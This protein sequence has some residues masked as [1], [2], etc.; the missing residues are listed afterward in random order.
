MR[1]TAQKNNSAV[2]KVQ[3]WVDGVR[4]LTEKLEYA[5]GTGC[6][7]SLSFIIQL[8]LQSGLDVLCT[9]RKNNSLFILTL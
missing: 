2:F 5:F 9:R 3:Q 4:C 1:D 6:I 8:L 7:L